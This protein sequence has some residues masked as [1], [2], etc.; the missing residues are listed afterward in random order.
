VLFHSP[1]GVLFT[2]PSRYLF[3]IGRQ[4]VLS[5]RGWAPQIHTGFLVPR[6]TRDP[7]AE[8]GR[9]SSTGLL[10]SVVG[11]FHGP[12]TS[13]RFC[14]SVPRPP[15][16]LVG[17]TTPARQRR[18][19]IT[20]CGFRLFPVRSP[21]LGESRLLSSPR[22]NEMFQFGRFPPQALWIQTWVAGHDPGPGFPIRT[23]S[24]QS[25]LGGSP[26]LFAA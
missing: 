23:P 8:T 5:L 13:C 26:R 24:D 3:T 25:L 14:N 9:L 11:R 18:W 7:H 1:P 17:P 19:A 15:S 16:Q 20:P 6:A 10:P 21:L 4:G 12:S 2:F 22:P